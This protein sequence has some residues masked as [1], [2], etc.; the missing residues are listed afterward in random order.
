MANKRTRS[1]SGV[2]ITQLSVPSSP[3][4]SSAFRA[5]SQ[6]KVCSS[7]GPNGTPS[8]SSRRSAVLAPAAPPADE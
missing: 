5:M 8:G 2:R 1:S 6:T 3:I 4:N 7:T